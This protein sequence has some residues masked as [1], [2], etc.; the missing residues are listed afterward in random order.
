M[1][2]VHGACVHTHEEYVIWLEYMI[3]CVAFFSIHWS[4]YTIIHDLEG[5]TKY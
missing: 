5:Y 3:L 1:Q 2:P 4:D